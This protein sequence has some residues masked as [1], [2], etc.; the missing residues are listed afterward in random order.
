M[1]ADARGSGSARAQELL[2]TVEEQVAARREQLAAL[3]RADGTDAAPAPAAEAPSTP[4]PPGTYTPDLES[5]RRLVLAPEPE[6]PSFPPPP[7]VEEEPAGAAELRDLAGAIAAIARRL[8]ELA[9][10]LERATHRITTPPPP[11]A[12]PPPPAPPAPR[13]GPLAQALSTGPPATS[14]ATD[15]GARLVAIEMAVAGA[16]RGEVALRLSRE[17]FGEDAA[18]ILDDV[19]GSGTAGATRM[20]WAAK[21]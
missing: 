6:A 7:P 1:T 13:S 2:R 17:F 18:P 12:P 21:P 4:P 20:P 9:T 10:R 3:R 8:E 14:A 11:A 5:P 15:L 16:T 19:F